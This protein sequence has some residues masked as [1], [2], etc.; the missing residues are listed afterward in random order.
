[1]IFVTSIIVLYAS[2]RIASSSEGRSSS[3]L[4]WGLYSPHTKL[5][6]QTIT[7]QQ[8]IL[9]SHNDISLIIPPRFCGSIYDYYFLE[10]VGNVSKRIILL[11]L[12]FF[13][14]KIICN[15]NSKKDLP[16]R[17]IPVITFTIPLFCR[18]ISLFK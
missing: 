17:L 7:V 15:L 12:F 13:C 14:G 16:Q 9:H 10:G 3:T 6:F 5:V 2:F 4:Y 18:S 11:L 8:K 1:M